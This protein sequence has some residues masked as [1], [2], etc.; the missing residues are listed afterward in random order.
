MRLA[1]LAAQLLASEVMTWA[2]RWLPDREHSAPGVRLPGT[3]EMDGVS[4]IQEWANKTGFPWNNLRPREEF[5][6]L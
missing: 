4:Y 1:C 3:S 2:L 5:E 6:Y